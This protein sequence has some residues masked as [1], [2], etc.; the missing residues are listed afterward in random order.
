M[1]VYPFINHENLCSTEVA[2]YVGEGEGPLASSETVS[3]GAQKFSKILEA[4][5]NFQVRQEWHDVMFRTENPHAV[6]A[7]VKMLFALGN[8]TRSIFHSMWSLDKHWWLKYHVIHRVLGIGNEGWRVPLGPHTFIVSLP[9]QK[10][11]SSP[12]N[13]LPLVMFILR[14]VPVMQL[15]VTVESVCDSTTRITEQKTLAPPVKTQTQ[16]YPY[17][18][19]ATQSQHFA[20]LIQILLKCLG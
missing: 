15:H 10:T 1:P 2:A 4:T 11:S 16:D 20:I 13:M 14:E 12:K 18:S 5:L 9:A 7:N 8:R 6:Y 19:S 17:D 3:P